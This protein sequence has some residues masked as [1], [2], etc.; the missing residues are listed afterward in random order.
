M[1]RKG[2]E[3]LF[4]VDTSKSM[5]TPDVKPDRLTR[6]KMAIDD[7]VNHLDGDGVGLIAFAGNAFLQCPITLDYDAF[8]E[9]LDA[10]D[11]NTIPRGGTDIA[12]AIREAQAAL[13]NRPGSDKILVLLT[14]GEDL[15][16]SAVD[17]AKAAAQAGLKIYTLGVGTANGDL[18]PLPAESGGG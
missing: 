17:A 5:L 3:I 16:G 14:D 9:S 12:N 2:V 13:Q 4:A 1:K 7:L 10:V 11:T 18:I 6:A 8:N 15:E